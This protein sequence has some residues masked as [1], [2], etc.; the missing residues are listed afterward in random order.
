MESVVHGEQHIEGTT[1]L[2][3]LQHLE[4]EADDLKVCMVITVMCLSVMQ[5]CG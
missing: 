3:D 5:G 2:E 4:D 1:R